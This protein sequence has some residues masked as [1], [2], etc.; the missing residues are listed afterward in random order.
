MQRARRSVRV[1]DLSDETNQGR[2]NAGSMMAASMAMAVFMAG[3]TTVNAPAGEP[4]RLA[5]GIITTAA[6]ALGLAG[7]AATRRACAA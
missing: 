5:L 3:A 6:A 1:M 7:L 2:N 4:S